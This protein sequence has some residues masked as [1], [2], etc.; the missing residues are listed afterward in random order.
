MASFAAD[1]VGV[2][3]SAQP[4]QAITLKEADGKITG[5]LKSA[6]GTLRVAEAKVDGDKVD[7]TFFVVLNNGVDPLGLGGYDAMAEE[8]QVTE[9]TY[10]GVIT[11]DAM[12]VTVSQEK[13]GEVAVLNF[14]KSNGD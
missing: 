4:A 6:L 7:L 5:T 11:G 12:K 3:K 9:I 13:L 14:K 1:V 10:K 2:W 8:G